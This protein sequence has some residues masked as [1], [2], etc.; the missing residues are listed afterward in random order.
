MGSQG[1]Y[2]D[3]RYKT[4]SS[5]AARAEYTR[6]KSAAGVLATAGA[7]EAGVGI[8]ADATTAIS[9][10]ALVRLLNGGGTVPMIA[11]KAI[12]IDTSVYTA[13][14]GKIT[15]SSAGGAVLLGTSLEA[16]G[17]DGDIIEVLLA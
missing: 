16:A 13:A 10:N 9:Q 14:S 15:D 2:T 11:S 12:A 1:Q 17:A 5:G 3:D 7:T 6:V 4:F 8:Q